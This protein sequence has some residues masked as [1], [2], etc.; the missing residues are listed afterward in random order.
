MTRSH[1]IEQ[2]SEA[3]QITTLLQQSLQQKN[4][5]RAISRAACTLQSALRSFRS[6]KMIRYQKS[7]RDS[8]NL[9]MR[10]ITGANAI[11]LA[12]KCCACRKAVHGLQV[13]RSDDRANSSAFS[14][15]YV[16]SAQ[17][18]EC[19]F[20][21]SYSVLQNIINFPLLFTQ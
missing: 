15:Q 9:F 7:T 13:Q 4:K 3:V 12:W 18:R 11:K 16:V 6:R 20:H 19:E 8:D 2:H 10:R 5:F 17:L 1:V 21:D 14:I